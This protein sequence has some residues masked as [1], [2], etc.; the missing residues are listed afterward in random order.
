[1]LRIP[2]HS[3]A[4]RA[5][6]L[7]V[8]LLLAAGYSAFVLRAWLAS[9][10]DTSLE[11]AP[12]DRAI[13][14]EPSNAAHHWVRGRIAYFAE[15]DFAA[16]V[17]HYRRAVALQPN[18]ARYWLD[19]ATAYE[20]LGQAAEERRALQQAMA[21]D[22][23]TPDLVREAASHYLTVGDTQ[24]AL[25]LLGRLAANHAPS[26]PAAVELSWRST[27]DPGR[28]LAV[29][30]RS[31]EAYLTFLQLL[32]KGG[33]T[34][35]AGVVWSRLVQLGHPVRPQ[36]AFPYIQHLLDRREV[37]QARAAW[38]QLATLDPSFEPYLGRGN[39]VTNP[40]FEHEV[41]NAGFGWRYHSSPA[42]TLEIAQ[43]DTHAGQ[44]SLAVTFNS[45][46]V[47][48]AGISQLVPVEPG[49][50][51][52]FSAFVKAAELESASPPR[53]AIFDAYSGQRL[54]L[55][56]EVAGTT[57]WL[58]LS[59]SFTAGPD[60][61]LVLLRIVREPGQTRIRGRLWLDDVSVVP[62]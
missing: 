35:A 39:L 46:A 28:V 8:C 3:R 33:E 10:L 43:A 13:R 5:A 34:A 45:Q 36:M 27:R 9:R 6:F 57:A 58:T 59:G 16:A 2:L 17:S 54:L 41:L 50:A 62:R 18:V 26:L 4:R 7:L 61:R 12:L 48:D 21:A 31:S 15:Q 30:P 42:V 19:L 23:T 22:P 38:S 1:M 44:R 53:F 37:E 14:L 29:L 11:A 49:R 52:D 60:T 32:V 47:Q 51:Y 55:T 24:L 40:G 20:V 25:Q 56:G